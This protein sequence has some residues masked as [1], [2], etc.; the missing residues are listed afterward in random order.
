ALDHGAYFPPKPVDDPA[1]AADADG[2]LTA[3]YNDD[4]GYIDDPMLSAHNLA[5][6]AGHH[7]AKFRF[8]VAVRAI[9][10]RDGHVTGVE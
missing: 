7:G 6:A 2:E 4:S 8:R 9:T 3:F 5:H 10:R 1:F